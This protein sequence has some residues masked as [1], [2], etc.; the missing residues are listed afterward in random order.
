MLEGLKERVCKANKD[1]V[2]H[3]LVLLNWGNLSAIDRSKNLIA[4]KPSGVDYDLLSPMDIVLVDMGGNIVE[5]DKKPSTD[6]VTHIELYKNFKGINSIIHTH[7]E[8]STV[9]AQAKKEIICM[10]TTHAD[11]FR[12]NI[13]V[14]RDL[15]IEEIKNDYERNTARIIIELFK[16]NNINPLEIPSCLVSS[17]APFV[18]GESIDKAIKN[19]VVLERISKMNLETYKI[20]GDI[21]PINPSL[22]DK[23]YFRKHG[24]NAYYG[25]NK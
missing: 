4:I 12:G 1:L 23:H 24:K 11:N 13:P 2:K 15:T 7:S 22:L 16:K 18:W 6:T 14:T 17:H 10:G 20:K 25:Q 3:K 9:F 21:K 8:Y 19:A 5:G